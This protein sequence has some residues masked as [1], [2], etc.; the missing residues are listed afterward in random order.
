MDQESIE[1][2]SRRQRAQEKFS[3]DREAVEV[4]VEA[5]ERKLDRNGICRA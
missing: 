3:M 1:M 4:S 5:G 2:L